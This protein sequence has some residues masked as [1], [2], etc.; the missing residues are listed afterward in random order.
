MTR[1]AFDDAITAPVIDIPAVTQQTLDVPMPEMVKQLVEVPKTPEIQ[2]RIQQRTVEQ[3][4]DVQ[5]QQIEEVP[6]IIKETA[7]RQIPIV[8]Q[9]VEMTTDTHTVAV[10]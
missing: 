8:V 3:I 6:K 2:D 4:V 1:V 7:Q 10:Y 9:T 5:V